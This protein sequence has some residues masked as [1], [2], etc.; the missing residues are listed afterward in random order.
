CFASFVTLVQI[1]LMS[2]VQ[3]KK[4]MT[5]L[6]QKFASECD[7]NSIEMERLKELEKFKVLEESEQLK[8]LEELEKLKNFE[9]LEK[10]KQLEELERSME[11]KEI[12]QCPVGSYTWIFTKT[13][14]HNTDITDLKVRFEADKEETASRDF[15]SPQ[16]IFSFLVVLGIMVLAFAHSLH[17]LLRPTSEYAYDQPSYTDD[18]NNPWNLVPSYKIISPNGTVEGSAIIETPDENTNLFSMFSTSLLAVYFMLTENEEIAQNLLP[19]I[20][21][22]VKTKYSTVN[23]AK[24]STDESIKVADESQNNVLKVQIDEALKDIVKAQIDE[25]LKGPIDKFNKLI[26][27]IEK[28]DK[29]S[30]SS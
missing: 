8:K 15:E 14:V 20:R 16:Q 6:Q 18:D 4:L 13:T 5:N 22:I 24:D 10:L 19:A 29:D 7:P 17:L 3:N 28:K 25:A 23:S 12:T 1:N 9:E 27:L 2:K 26:E 21:K 11:P 30:T